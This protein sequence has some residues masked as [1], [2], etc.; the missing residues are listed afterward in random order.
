MELALRGDRGWLGGGGRVTV[1]GKKAGGGGPELKL[2]NGG[3]KCQGGV[4]IGWEGGGE[5]KMVRG[6]RTG[7][8]SG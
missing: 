3:G 5:M 2:F 4:H 6:G 7:G 8:D 1:E